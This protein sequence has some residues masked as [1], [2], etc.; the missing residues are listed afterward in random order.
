MV[1]F[2]IEYTIHCFTSFYIISTEEFTRIYKISGIYTTIQ[3]FGV[4]NLILLLSKIITFI[5]S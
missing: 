1:T 2:L 5:K 4:S 3:M